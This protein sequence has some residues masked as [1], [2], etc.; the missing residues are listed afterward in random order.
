MFQTLTDVQHGDSVSLQQYIDNRAG[1]LCIG[2]RSLT[3]WV[4]WWNWDGGEAFRWLDPGGNITKHSIPPGLYPEADITGRISDAIPSLQL[5]VGGHDGIVRL[6]IPARNKVFLSDP[7]R[8]LYGLNDEGWLT[9]GIY[10]GDRPVHFLPS[11]AVGLR[12]HQLNTTDNVVDG[13]PSNILAHL[14][15]PCTKFG[16]AWSIHFSHPEM[17]PLQGGAINELEVELVDASGRKIDN[18][19][20]PV[21]VTLEIAPKS[22]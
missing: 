1:N 10:T 19:G 7:L 22:K 6:T 4:G 5:A 14:S 21:H 17:K 15:A 11:K 3:W 8:Q 18:H 13:A 9:P 16:E 2:L 20:L 12:L